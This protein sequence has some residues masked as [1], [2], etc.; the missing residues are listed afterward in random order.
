M[1]VFCE[2]Q[3]TTAVL[4]SDRM[5]CN[6]ILITAERLGEKYELNYR[7]VLWEMCITK[8]CWDTQKICNPQHNGSK[9]NNNNNNINM[10]SD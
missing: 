9:N 3:Y 7:H 2:A 5:Q 6:K 4:F 8:D 10:K 1:L